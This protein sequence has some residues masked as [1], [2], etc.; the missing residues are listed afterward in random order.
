[1]S[2]P[3][4]TILASPTLAADRQVR[5][6]LAEAKDPTDSY[7]CACEHTARRGLSTTLLRRWTSPTLV[8]CRHAEHQTGQVVAWLRSVNLHAH[9]KSFETNQIT[10]STLLTLTST[11]LQAIGITRLADRREIL[12]QVAR[13]RAQPVN[14]HLSKKTMADGRILNLLSGESIF[15]LWA[16]VSIIMLLSATASIRLRK[17]RNAQSAK[18]VTITAEVLA[19]LA[20]FVILYA[21]YQL[22]VSIAMADNPTNHPSGSKVAVILPTLL[23]II[24]TLVTLYT[25]MAEKASDAAIL[26]LLSL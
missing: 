16:R 5:I 25:I 10:P 17:E 20:I 6:Q 2:F 7:S 21:F 11:E 18:Y 15:L 4:P 19:T 14:R 23:T 12:A 13:Q 3:L 26:I 1:M 9:V 22:S 24:A 8:P